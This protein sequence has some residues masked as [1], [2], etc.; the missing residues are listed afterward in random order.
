MRERSRIGCLPEEGRRLREKIGMKQEQAAL[1]V[2]TR[3][4]APQ[5]DAAEERGVNVS[6]RRSPV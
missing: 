4:G 5:A 6:S 2:R 1:F 3:I